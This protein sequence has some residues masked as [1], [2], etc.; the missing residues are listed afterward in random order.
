LQGFP[1][2]TRRDQAGNSARQRDDD[3]LMDGEQ[4]AAIGF[5]L[6]RFFV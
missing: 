4:G 5:R 6:E 1:V 2:F 3:V